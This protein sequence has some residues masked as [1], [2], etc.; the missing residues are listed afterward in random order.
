MGILKYY[1]NKQFVKSLLHIIEFGANI[2]F[3]GNHREQP[4][5]NLKSTIEFPDSVSKAVNTLVTSHHA[6]GPFPAPPYSNFWCSTL[7]SITCPCKPLKCRLIHHLS[8]P[9]GASVNDGIPD[10]E[11]HIQYE[12]FNR[13]VSAIAIFGKN[14][15][16]AKLDLKEAFHH[17]LVRQ[18]DWQLL[19]FEW[20]GLFYHAI[21]LMFGLKSAP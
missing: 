9:H 2:G 21:V 4:C 8:S 7:G 16:L 18:D 17:I 3:S 20:Q 5:H 6:F 11:G 15:L 1:P 13:A 10:S 14:T 12:V 19:G